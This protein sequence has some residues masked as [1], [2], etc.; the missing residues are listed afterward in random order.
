MKNE[1][2]KKQKAEVLCPEDDSSPQNP[3]MGENGL[4]TASSPQPVRHLHHVPDSSCD[5]RPT[6]RK[7]VAPSHPR[8]RG[9]CSSSTTPPGT[10]SGCHPLNTSNII[11]TVGVALVQTP[12]AWESNHPGPGCMSGGQTGTS[13]PLPWEDTSSRALRAVVQPEQELCYCWK[14]LVLSQLYLHRQLGWRLGG[15]GEDV[16]RGAPSV[17]WRRL[18]R[19]TWVG[20]LLQGQYVYGGLG[21]ISKGLIEGHRRIKEQRGWR[22]LHAI[23]HHVQVLGEKTLGA[24]HQQEESRGALWETEA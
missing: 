13:P 15:R 5:T 10:G 19:E 9:D 22:T 14:P 21:N 2:Q 20:R 12:A 1:T 23:T 24:A 17:R 3:Q 8:R 11:Q 4:P 18:Q 16:S 7:R 6:H